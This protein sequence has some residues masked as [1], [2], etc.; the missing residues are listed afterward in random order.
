MLDLV[1]E[2]KYLEC[3]ID[4]KKVNSIERK[5]KK[6]SDLRKKVVGAM[7]VLVKSRNLS[8]E[9]ARGLH[10]EVLYLP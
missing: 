7:E 1:N 5:L 10:E 2:F 6:N 9:V 4:K 3:V 8:I